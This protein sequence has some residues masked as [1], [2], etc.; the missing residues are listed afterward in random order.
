VATTVRTPNNIYILNDIGKDRCFLGMENESRIWHI[1]MGHMNFDYLVKINR[2]EVVREMDEIKF[3]NQSVLCART[4][5]MENKQELNSNQRN[6][7][8]KIHW[9]LC[10]LIYMDQ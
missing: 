7:L 1:R 10:T 3:Q 5:H 2:K 9:K 8:Q 6:T 4:S